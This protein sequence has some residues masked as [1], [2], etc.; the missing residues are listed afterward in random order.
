[1]VSEWVRPGSQQVAN[2]I[3]PILVQYNK[4]KILL[5]SDPLDNGLL[6]FVYRCKSHVRCVS[7]DAAISISR[8]FKLIR[9][10]LSITR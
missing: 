2:Y 7:I 1:M 3:A 5:T 9:N 6:Q 4:G 8:W 10:C